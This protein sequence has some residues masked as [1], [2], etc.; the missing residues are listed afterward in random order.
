[1][2]VIHAVPVDSEHTGRGGE[3][4]GGA[5]VPETNAVLL[6][7]ERPQRVAYL[8]RVVGVR[9]VETHQ[10]EL[11]DVDERRDAELLEGSREEHV[12]EHDV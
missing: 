5:L 6:D 10:Y 9:D 7:E 4:E 1:M 11:L 3:G 12:G 2:L 8:V